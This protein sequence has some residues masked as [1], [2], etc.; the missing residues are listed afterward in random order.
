M[1]EGGKKDG[2]E[3]GGCLHGWILWLMAQ[4]WNRDG[5]GGGEVVVEIN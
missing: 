4:W 1:A 2:G 5:G 3:K